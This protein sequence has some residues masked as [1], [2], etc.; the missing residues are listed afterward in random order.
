M[1]APRPRDWA[2]FWSDLLERQAAHLR[3]LEGARRVLKRHRARRV[4]LTELPDGRIRLEASLPYASPELPGTPRVRVEAHHGG[5][6]TKLL[7]VLAREGYAAPPQL[8][9]DLIGRA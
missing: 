7:Q 3:D 9:S 4:E 1:K 2:S 6:R 5:L 8:V